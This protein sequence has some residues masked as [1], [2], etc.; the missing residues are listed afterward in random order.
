MKRLLF[1]LTPL[2]ISNYTTSQNGM[3]VRGTF[4]ADNRDDNFDK[5]IVKKVFNSK[6]I[7]VID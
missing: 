2:E 1:T 6:F 3:S 4:L 5:S 7:A